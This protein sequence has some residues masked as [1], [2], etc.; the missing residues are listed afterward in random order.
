MSTPNLQYPDYDKEFIL[1]TDASAYAIGSVLSQGSPPNDRPI[2][3]AVRT[4]NHSESNDSTTEREMLAIV[5][6]I[7][8]F[9]P[10]LYGT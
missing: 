5:W 8:H 1:T 7:K 2:A 4:L 10:Y 9:R 3:Y 6:S